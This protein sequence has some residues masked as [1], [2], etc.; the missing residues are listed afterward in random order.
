M[1]LPSINTQP[2]CKQPLPGLDALYRQIDAA[3]FSFAPAEVMENWLK[4]L[5]PQG[6]ADWPQFQA[7]WENMPGDTY[8]ADGGRYRSR[9]HA[10][11]STASP[12]APIVLLPQQPHYQ[13]LDYNPLNGG[14]A[15]HFAPI[16]QDIVLG[17]TMQ[18]VLKFCQLVFGRL[19]PEAAWHIELHQF[20]IE[21]QQGQAGK[22]TPEGVHRDG[23]NFV[24]VMMVKRSNISSG[25]TTMHD[26]ERRTLDSF[27]LTAPFDSAI[28][29]DE[30]CLHGVTP[31]EQI[32]PALPA[33]R[34]VL[35]VT[36]RKSIDCA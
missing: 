15:R 13:S 16:A 35:V 17:A 25:T 27:T 3:G 20:R 30:R 24:L 28:V 26:L 2:T 34:D 36:F 4:A 14:L 32:D 5:S 29:N 21:A 18:G 19:M 23:V 22:P 31:V 6:L 7:S 10:T 12:G 33:Y 9:R 1:T 11:L 8:M